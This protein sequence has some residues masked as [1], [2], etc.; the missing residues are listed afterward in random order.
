MNV[1]AIKG[2][3]TCFKLRNFAAALS[4]FVNR[5]LGH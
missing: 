5:K 3:K 4:A 2:N 1:A